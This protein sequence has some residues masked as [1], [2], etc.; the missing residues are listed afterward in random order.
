MSA[1]SHTEAETIVRILANDRKDGVILYATM[2]E[3]ALS[4]AL[5]RAAAVTMSDEHKAASCAT[6]RMQ[7]EEDKGSGGGPC[8]R[9]SSSPLS[10]LSVGP[11]AHFYGEPR[12]DSRMD[13]F[14]VSFAFPIDTHTT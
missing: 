5:A 9:I 4:C 14:D 10:S 11:R 6:S 8:R 13:T 1:L 12:Y 7:R 2:M 3:D